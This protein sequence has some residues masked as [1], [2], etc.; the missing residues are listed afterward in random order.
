M[1]VAVGAAVVLGFLAPPVASASSPVV[2][3]NVERAIL[4]ATH[5][6]DYLPTAGALGS[7]RYHSFSASPSGVSVWFRAS[8]REVGFHTLAQRV[9][10]AAGPG[11]ETGGAMRTFRVGATRIYWRGTT[12]DHEAWR[13]LRAHGRTITLE[14]TDAFFNAPDVSQRTLRSVLSDVRWLG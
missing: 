8:G 5:V 4:K 12:E 11:N 6:Y 2:Q 13:C 14:A 10:C 3:P 7:Y 9:P 1:R